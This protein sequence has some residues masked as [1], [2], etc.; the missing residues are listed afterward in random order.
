MQCFSDDINSL[1]HFYGIIC[2]NCLCGYVNTSD[3]DDDDDVSSGDGVRG[4]GEEKI[5]LNTIHSLNLQNLPDLIRKSQE[6]IV[7]K[8]EEEEIDFTD[9]DPEY[10][11]YKNFT[12]SQ[13]KTAFITDSTLS[14]R[15][16]ETSRS[17]FSSTADLTP[18]EID[19]ALL[20][21]YKSIVHEGDIT[22]KKK[23]ISEYE[24]YK[25]MYD[26]NNKDDSEQATFYLEAARNESKYKP[27]ERISFYQTAIIFTN[28]MITKDQIKAEYIS[29]CNT[30][31]KSII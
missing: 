9:F 30:L 4:I 19:K 13:V 22:K 28:N 14:Q 18:R 25:S 29:F 23:Y 26:L 20:N 1:D 6:S 17:I 5:A 2:C 7:V 21:L 15:S 3:D 16:L 27:K 24:T 11:F 8:E 31:K 12:R 10:D